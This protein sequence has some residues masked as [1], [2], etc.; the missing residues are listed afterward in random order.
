MTQDQLILAM[1]ARMHALESVLAV[2]VA[3]RTDHAAVMEQAEDTLARRESFVTRAGYEAGDV[4][5]V[6]IA[7]ATLD[8]LDGDIAALRRRAGLD[9]EGGVDPDASH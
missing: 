4:E 5:L 1:M 9:Q 2:L 3:F 6:T 7:R 8:S